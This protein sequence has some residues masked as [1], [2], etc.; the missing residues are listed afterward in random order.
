MSGKILN[1]FLIFLESNEIFRWF[2]LKTTKKNITYCTNYCTNYFINI[3]RKKNMYHIITLIF[4]HY[5]K[6]SLKKKNYPIQLQFQYKEFTNQLY[7]SQYL[8]K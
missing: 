2:F 7:N 1:I 3:S 5:E 8:S 6:S 4:T